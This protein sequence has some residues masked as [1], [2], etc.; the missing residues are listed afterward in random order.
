MCEKDISG[1][2]SFIEM[3]FYFEA[4]QALHVIV[5][6]QKLMLKICKIFTVTNIF[7]YKDRYSLF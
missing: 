6:P 7:F 1:G 2:R 5:L 3:Q 4:S